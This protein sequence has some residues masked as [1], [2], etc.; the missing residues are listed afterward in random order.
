MRRDCAAAII[1]LLAI[2]SLPFALGSTA[3]ADPGVTDNLDGTSTAL[4]NFSTPGNYTLSN[5]RIGG[6]VASLA[7]Q[8]GWWNS[9]TQADFS[10]PDA[11]TNITWTAWPGDVG[12]STTS[13][14][15]TVLTLQPGA[16]GEDAWLDQAIPAAN[17]GA[18]TTFIVDGRNPQSRPIL[19][20]DLSSLPSNVV[21]D[22]ATLSLY[23]NAG[24][25]NNV[26]ARLRLVTAAWV[27]AQAT[28]TNRQTGIPWG[29]A[30]GD[31]NGKIIDQVTLD[32]SV[33]W[34]NWNA[35]VL[36]DLWYRNRVPNYGL[37]LEA[38]DP[39]QNSDKTFYSSDY[40]VNASLRPKLTIR[41][42]PVGVLGDYVSKVGG[43]GISANWGTI[44]WN[45]TDR[46]LITDEF[47]GASLDPKWT[48]TNPP[49]TYDVGTTTPGH[50]HVVSCTA[51]DLIG[52]T[53]TGNVLA[54]EVVGNFTATM[55]F[56]TS[57]TLNGQKAGL[58]ALL[59]PRDWYNVGKQ[60]VLGT[61][62][63]NWRIRST[64]DAVTTT[65]VDM[66]SGNPNPAWVRIQR[67]GN[68]FTSSTSSDGTSWTLQDT[69]VPAL[70][71]PLQ[72]RL[73]LYT[74][75][76]LSGTALATDV[77]YVRV[78]HDP[79]TTVTVRT[80]TGNVSPVDGTWS[81]WSVP[82]ASSTGSAIGAASG[83]IEFRLELGVVLPDHTPVVGDVNL[84]WSRYLSAGT[85]T[86]NDLVPSDLAGW[87]NLTV[88]QAANG[89]S[90][91]YEYSLDSGATWSA[92]SPPANL[93]GV[94]TTSGRIRFRASLTTTDPLVSPTLT[95]IR[96][97][98]LH[99][100]DHFYVAVSPAATAGSPFTVTVAAKDAG[101]F[102]MTGWT[103]V[104]A[105]TARLADGVTPGGGTLGTTTM[106]ISAGGTATLTTQT[107]TK[108]ETIRLRA[109]Y[110]AASGLSGSVLV[111]PGP[112]ARIAVSPS[113][114]SLRALD[115]QAFAAQGFDAWDNMV[116]GVSFTWSVLGGVGTLNASS[117]SAVTFSARAPPASGAVQA[118]SGAFSGTAA[119]RVVSAYP[120]VVTAPFS[121]VAFDEDTI[122]LNALAGNV[123]AH[124]SDADGEPLT[125]SI[126]GAQDVAFRIN[127]DGTVDL[128]AAANWS[129]SETL[130]VRATD[131]TGAFVEAPLVVLVRPVNDAPIL[132]P[133]P[134]F[135]LD[136]GTS[137]SFDLTPY[138][139]DIDTPLSSITVT[140]DSPYVSV[141]GH[142]LTIALPSDRP[143]AD[144]TVTI[145]DGAATA[146]RPARAILVSPWWQAS[147]FAVPPIGVF[148]VIA[149]LVQRA[150]WRPAK[151]FLVDEKNRMLREFT[152]DP[153]CRVTYDQAVQAGV[154][155]AVEK[156]VKVE[157]YRGQTVRGDA[158]A[159][160]LLAYGPVTLEQVEF[161]RE[162]LVQV[163]D[164]FADAVKE[165]LAEAR[166]REGE[167][168]AR[169]RELEQKRA[170]LE[171]RAGELRATQEEIDRVRTKIEADQTAI[172]AAD[173][174]LKLRE[175]RLLEERQ[176]MDV[177]AREVEATRAGFDSREA[178]AREEEARLAAKAESLAAR[179]SA[180][181][182]AEAALDERKGGIAR[183][184]ER[185]AAEKDRLAS[186]AAAI[187]GRIEAAEAREAQI[188]TGNE[189]LAAA[190][191]RFETEQRDLLEFKQSVDARV[192][193]VEK[194][195]A[196]AAAKAQELVAREGRLAPFEAELAGREAAAKAA[197][198]R[199][200]DEK[201]AAD[202]QLAELASR[203]R[204]LE[205]REV[206]L[207]E[208]RVVIEEA[209]ASFESDRNEFQ[210][211]TAHYEEELRR[212]QEDL[213]GQAKEIGEQQLRLASDR[214]TF[215]RS[216]NEKNQAILAKEIEVEA[217]EQS[218]L[219]KE[220]SVRS[221]AE[222]N[223]R[224]IA[225]LASREESVEIEGARL[226][227]ERADL[228]ARKEE[229]ATLAKEL[230]GKAARLRE[231]ETRR[232]E[233][234][235]T[236]QATLES[237]QALLKEQKETFEQE[238]AA[239]RDSWSDRV[240][241]VERREAKAAEQE[242]KV[243]ADL[244]W[245]A[246]NKEELTRREAAVQEASRQAAQ[247]KAEGE[248][249]KQEVE[250]EA[251]EV[252]SR[253][254]A[255]REDAARHAVELTK[256]TN[257][258]NA[259]EA[260]LN[261][262]RMEFE[263][264]RIA[265]T[266]RIHEADLNLQKMSQRLDEKARELTDREGKIAT[267]E[268]ALRSEAARLEH[269]R[270][271]VQ[272]T[273]K[274]LEAQQ[275]EL[276][277]LRDRYEAESARVRTET[278]AMRQSLAAREAEVRAERERIER[279][280][281]VLQDTLGAKAKE[282]AIREKAL[283]AREAELRAEEEEVDA[284]IRELES[285]ERQAE[286]RTTELA[287]QA[288]GLVRREGDLNTR[289]SQFDETVKKFEAEER[290][291]RQQL[292][293][294]QAAFRNEKRQI[295]ATV[296]S[297]SAEL[298]QRLE[299]VEARERSLRAA[300]T[301]LQLERSKLEAQA[302]AA[303]AKASEAEAAWSRSEGRLAEL[304]TMEADLLRARQAF[305][306]E[307]STWAVKRSEELKQLEAT[308][309]A[310]AA[311]AQQ[312]ER[313]I[314]ES[315]RRAL[316]ADEAEKAAKRQV[317]DA[318]NQLTQLERRRSEVDKSEREAQATLARLQEASQ[319]LAAKEAEIASATRDLEVRS[320]KL[321]D[322]E[323]QAT[324]AATELRTRKGTIDLETTRLAT[325]GQQLAARQKDLET[326]SSILDAKL[327]EAAQK[328]H[329]MTTEL[330]RADNLMEDLT[331]K[332]RDLMA[333]EEKVRSL[334]SE[335]GRRE[336]SLA[337]R[338]GQLAEG[339]RGL[340]KA[341][342]E[343]EAQRA[344]AEEELRAAG[345]SRGDAE[346]LRVQAEG[347][348]AEVSKNL[349][350]LQKKA[351]DVLDKEEKLREREAAVEHEERAL[352]TRAE[353]LEGKERAIEADRSE[354]ETR[355][356]RLQ[357]EVDRLR[358]RLTEIDKGSGPS[359]AAME[360]W[361]KDVENR[362]KI[363]QKKAMELLDREQKLR[364]KE[365]ELRALAAQL[366]VAP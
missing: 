39:G 155:D 359:S 304:K 203:F 290:E 219:E 44:S 111:S 96:L 248:R 256:R 61:G 292:E 268:E 43:D 216:R 193:E 141:S 17:H 104:V 259:L 117:G 91:A 20:F 362:V 31:Y 233:E 239:A 109:T 357:A 326:R 264:D 115:T 324:A 101:N 350:F 235:R 27:E 344:R 364:D 15:S 25:N 147:Y 87:G 93:A 227:K 146:S 45:R 349:R 23:E 42:R 73:A 192:A 236:W 337:G 122:D 33:G 246:Q 231:E 58:M 178:Q 162:M 40:A 199:A 72:V 217:R 318:A 247:L 262:K 41:Y 316:V 296:E 28:W 12:L 139:S 212:R 156:P 185:L 175:S 274:Q 285:K 200:R 240:M 92:V 62:T 63:V 70:E 300:T 234:L 301:Q 132:A 226:D 6:G 116:G 307:R 59:G 366:G 255:L 278:E 123:T 242:E 267:T 110:L 184:E 112:L 294:L 95:E 134:E 252:G 160:V 281:T 77:D 108:A 317:A 315:Q 26:I 201:S 118:S 249:L 213:A 221:Q 82:Y 14:P 131:P 84:S 11:A 308:R 348:Q 1:L 336:S 328:E 228:G 90:I 314:A 311:Q 288:M 210:D 189:E 279:D 3:V 119:V 282:M 237:Q 102:T 340:E 313:I 99:N 238:A 150:R 254:R 180:V 2:S 130:R 196:D 143:Q 154:L 69:Y 312:T 86:T 35:T 243:R 271:T 360:E 13:G 163:Q 161:A 260:D 7:V 64:V 80:R 94:P 343:I 284:R 232:A 174:D 250:Q 179:E 299:D 356:G 306:S 335:L 298:A 76:G 195:E 24:I 276:E 302:K 8:S 171:A 230:D 21:I 263:R 148:V 129:G 49:A 352:D 88:V 55:K 329:M 187:Q 120:P 206:A 66:N 18:D 280:S 52:P 168:D 158:M 287:A 341:R 334:E 188:R 297:R 331:K 183:E 229:L 48:W 169:A 321:V 60:Y 202:A 57:P 215:E 165:R 166:T 170:E 325:L 145:S 361:K 140:T 47:N 138:I 29:T 151:A 67:A 197:E 251:M 275:L 224:R 339:L 342:Q 191:Q 22:D 293:A 291:K 46:S 225:E 205:A 133:L 97:T 30:G 105:L 363:I 358:A 208:D 351:L 75:D 114:V 323:K 36:V 4:W 142:T 222:D 81:G 98:F 167:L 295:T 10:G 283:A 244:E 34:R 266:E 220:E 194:A 320:A 38:P 365:A 241:R 127:G 65:R 68:T 345:A 51:C 56:T 121:S 327:A 305:E 347:M 149:M 79:D 113:N 78:A 172:A 258:L 107:Y 322:S 354:L 265:Q 211:R 136:P 37:L 128:W 89:Q 54:N 152:L 198:A 332:E 182:S 303:S 257:T 16:A 106:A 269:E 245:V 85:L 164:K 209:R 124:F 137:A 186:E 218:L 5:A 71:Y 319:K 338:E 181:V 286:S 277:Q 330:Q 32:N 50:L 204:E 309:D 83:Y 177:L 19:R 157:K 310:T 125:F 176:A 74:A 223:S 333:R 273:G 346:K 135:R 53:F 144:F 207:S 261:A 272:E 253:E 190:R 353:I 103:G 100:L 289:A 159:V 214:D 126:L 355:A 153:S 9:T 270:A 173:S